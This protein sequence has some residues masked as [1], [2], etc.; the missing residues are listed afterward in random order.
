MQVVALDRRAAL[1]QRV[2]LAPEH[3]YPAD[4]LV[5][6]WAHRVEPK[7]RG[8]LE[9]AL[10]VVLRVRVGDAGSGAVTPVG[11]ERREV[12]G[13]HIAA[14]VDVTRTRRSPECEQLR[15]VQGV[16]QLV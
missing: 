13:I 16:H 8:Q 1:R 7:Q 6:V 5:R 10:G 12:G 4:P 3:L 15:E 2:L 14:A 9:N 11:E